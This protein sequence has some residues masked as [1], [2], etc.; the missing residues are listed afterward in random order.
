[1]ERESLNNQIRDKVLK[2]ENSDK[3]A[4]KWSS[5]SAWM[6]LEKHVQKDDDIASWPRYLVAIIVIVFIAIIGIFFH[7]FSENSM[8][9]DKVY[10][11]QQ[12][13]PLD[14]YSKEDCSDQMLLNTCTETEEGGYIEQTAIV[15]PETPSKRSI[16]ATNKKRAIDQPTKEVIN[17]IAVDEKPSHVGTVN[18]N[19]AENKQDSSANNDIISLETALATN[20]TIEKTEL[21]NPQVKSILVEIKADTVPKTT[22]DEKKRSLKFK[23]FRREHRRKNKARNHTSFT[24]LSNN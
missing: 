16:S 7:S 13:N 24:T 18:I 14:S 1:M 2:F 22:L 3:L 21:D 4:E 6:R 12:N 23:I 5:D 10:I 8:E 15:V 17:E 11:T 19:I 9:V 20:E